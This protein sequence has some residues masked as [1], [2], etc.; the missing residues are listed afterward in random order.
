MEERVREVRRRGGG[1]A[2]GGVVDG[3]GFGDKAESRRVNG[4]GGM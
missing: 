3:V 1:G 4:N 2:V